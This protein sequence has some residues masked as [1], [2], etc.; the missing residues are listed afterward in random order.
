MGIIFHVAADE[1]EAL[2]K[3]SAEREDRRQRAIAATEGRL[4]TRAQINA[5]TRRE[6]ISHLESRGTACFREDT[7]QELRECALEEAKE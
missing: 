5:M 2:E 4:K 1:R 7:T 3:A 6:L